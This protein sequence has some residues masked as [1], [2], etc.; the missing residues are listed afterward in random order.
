MTTR[1]DTLSDSTVLTRTWEACCKE[2]PQALHA[3]ESATRLLCNSRNWDSQWELHLNLLEL[4][5]R[6]SRAESAESVMLLPSLKLPRKLDNYAKT[7]PA[8]V[9]L[10]LCAEQAFYKEKLKIILASL[11]QW[12]NFP[13][14]TRT[15]LTR[16][17][18]H[19]PFTLNGLVLILRRHTAH[20]LHIGLLADFPNT[21]K[22]LCIKGLCTCI[23]LDVALLES[24]Q[25]RQ[26]DTVRLLH[27]VAKAAS[28][29]I[30][31]MPNGLS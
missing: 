3:G 1:P 30:S 26:A 5:Q 12:T 7:H 14:R 10:S 2:Q 25:V 29:W 18:L 23:L 4:L 6:G 22:W 19:K 31:F 20:H 17:R 28:I 16:L 15:Y 9:K 24:I 13:G 8:S 11:A 27:M 21:Q